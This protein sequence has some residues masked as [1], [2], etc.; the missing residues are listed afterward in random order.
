MVVPA[1]FSGTV[2][3]VWL[4]LLWTSY[5][6]AAQPSSSLLAETVRRFRQRARNDTNPVVVQEQSTTFPTVLSIT[7]TVKPVCDLAYVLALLVCSVQ[8]R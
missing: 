8:S 6:L 5:E 1:I 7:L 3:T 2:F 4:S